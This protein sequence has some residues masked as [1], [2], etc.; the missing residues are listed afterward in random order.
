[1]ESAPI[2]TLLLSHIFKLSPLNYF[3]SR[4]TSN[5][6]RLKR[7]FVIDCNHKI[8]WD[9]KPWIIWMTKFSWERANPTFQRSRRQSHSSSST[10]RKE[11]SLTIFHLISVLNHSF[12]FHS[13]WNKWRR[14]IIPVRT[15]RTNR[16]CCSGRHV[17]YR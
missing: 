13:V 6:D 14:K 4:L 10:K 5:F 17:P 12:F 1:M 2:S 11:V 9:N 3:N 15:E 7:R 16:Y 8:I